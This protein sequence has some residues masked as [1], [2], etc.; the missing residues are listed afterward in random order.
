MRVH[1]LAARTGLTVAEAQS[2]LV[3]L[4]RT[5]P[6]YWA[7][8]Q[9]VISTA[10]RRRHMVVPFDGWPFHV[11]AGTK[12]TAIKNSPMQSFG[13]AA[14]RLAAIAAV[15]EGLRIGAMVHD[16]FALVSTIEHI[17]CDTAHLC[18]I[19]ADA[20]ERVCG[21]RIPASFEIIRYPDR[22]WDE[23]DADAI[24]FWHR[25]MALLERVEQRRRVA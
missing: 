25:M 20:A 22:Y 24:A 18:E 8:S 21:V 16:A 2:L 17:E 14:L 4:A 19:M 7:W 23:D 15:E 6:T 1:S 9:R 13:S 5:Y 10:I 11:H 3:A 12:H